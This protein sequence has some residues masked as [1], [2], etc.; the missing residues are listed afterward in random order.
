MANLKRKR[1]SDVEESA[2]V[3]GRCLVGSVVLIPYGRDKLL[4]T[5]ISPVWT[6]KT[7]RKQKGKSGEVSNMPR[8]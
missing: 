7:V 5:R 8:I 4:R 1:V 3:I 6:M 2:K